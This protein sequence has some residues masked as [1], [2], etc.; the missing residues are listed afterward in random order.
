MHLFDAFEVQ[1]T[2]DSCEVW[3]F[4]YRGS[5]IDRVGR[6]GGLDGPIT[7]VY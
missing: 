4:E 5:V 6:H 7:N 3:I 1:F 2:M